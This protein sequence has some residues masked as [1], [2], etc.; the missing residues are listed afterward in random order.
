MMLLYDTVRAAP[1]LNGCNGQSAGMRKGSS[2]DKGLSAHR[3]GDAPPDDFGRLAGR[4]GSL[5]SAWTKLA[6]YRAREA[7]LQPTRQ[8]EFRSQEIRRRSLLALVLAPFSNLLQNIGDPYLFF[9]LFWYRLQRT[10]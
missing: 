1:W 10:Y 3:T 7:I 5:G 8:S 2:A 6:G 9:L 4:S